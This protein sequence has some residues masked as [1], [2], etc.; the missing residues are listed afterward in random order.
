VNV[1]PLDSLA[2]TNNGVCAF[3]LLWLPPSGGGDS[4]MH[5]TMKVATLMVI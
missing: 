3:S 4:A 2:S 1:S 5:T